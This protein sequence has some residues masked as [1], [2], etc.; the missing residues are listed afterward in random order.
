MV[1]QATLERVYLDAQ[2]ACGLKEDDWVTVTKSA[3]IHDTGWPGL[4]SPALDTYIGQ[5]GKVT[6][7]DASG[8]HVRF[9]ESDNRI[10]PYFVLEKTNAPQRVSAKFKPFEKVL[11]RDGIGHIW[12]CALFS[13]MLDDNFRCVGGLWQQCI[14]Y[15]GNEHL[16]GATDSPGTR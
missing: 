3:V 8:V 15:E 2:A 13:H 4:W 12:N 14:P 7:L 10:L 1:S 11:V 5:T 6:H 16:V 9:S